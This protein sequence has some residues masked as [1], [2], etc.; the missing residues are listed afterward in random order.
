MDL[1]KGFTS[2]LVRRRVPV[3]LQPNRKVRI[4]IHTNFSRSHS[5]YYV[6]GLYQKTGGLSVL[7]EVW[8][9]LLE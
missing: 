1:V 5:K 2:D 4:H 3:H 9:L 8:L 6:T 7:L